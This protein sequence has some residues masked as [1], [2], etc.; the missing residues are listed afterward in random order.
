MPEKNLNISRGISD[1]GTPRTLHPAWHPSTTLTSKAFL[2]T[3]N[4]LE[5]TKPRCIC[6]HRQLCQDGA[7][8]IRDLFSN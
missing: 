8:E 6:E 5:E 7:S 2:S 4:E 3:I 1:R